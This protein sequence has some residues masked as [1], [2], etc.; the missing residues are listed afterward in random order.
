M[1]N[2]LALVCL[3]VIA[4]LIAGIMVETYWDCRLLQRGSITECMPPRGQ[5][6]T[7]RLGVSPTLR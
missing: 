3:V 7:P 2:R 1:D 4:V 6:A 5:A